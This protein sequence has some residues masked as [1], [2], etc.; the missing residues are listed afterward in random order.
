MLS[1]PGRPVQIVVRLAWTILVLA[2]IAGFLASAW[3]PGDGASGDLPGFRNNGFRIDWVIQDAHQVLQPGDVIREINH[4]SINA[5]ISASPAERM[6]RNG[7]TLTFTVLRNNQ[8]L[9]LPVTLRHLPLGMVI[10]RYWFQLLMAFIQM[11]IGGFMLLKRQDE[12]PARVL[13]LFTLAIFF[14][15]LGDAYNFSPSA[16]YQGWPFWIHF[17]EEQIT[18]LIASATITL[19]CIVF[20]APRNLK[21][22]SLFLINLSL[23]GLPLLVFLLVSFIVTPGSKALYTGNQALISACSVEYLLAIIVLVRKIRTHREQP[24]RSQIQWLVACG[25]FCVLILVPSYF[26][27]LVLGIPPFLTSYT[28]SFSLLIIPLVIAIAI[29]RYRM[30]DIE[31]IL[32]QSLIYSILTA[33]LFGLFVSV[34]ILIQEILFSFLPGGN[35]P[36]SIGIATLITAAVFNPFRN[37]LQNWIDGRFYRERVDMRK[38][39]KDFADNIRFSVDLPEILKALSEFITR[40]LNSA[41]VVIYLAEEGNIFRKAEMRGSVIGFDANISLEPEI[42]SRLAG[43]GY[44]ENKKGTYQLWVPLTVADGKGGL[45]LLGAMVAGPHLMERSFRGDEVQFMRFISDHV[46]VA[47]ANASYIHEQTANV[48]KQIA[49]YHS[50]VLSLSKA[51]DARDSYTYGHSD[52]I[53]LLSQKV[54]D[55]MGISEQGHEVL[56]WAS[57]LHDI[58]KIGVRDSILF[59][60]GKLT[61]E[62]WVEMKKHPDI[63]AD[64]IARLPGLEQVSEIIRC[65][66]ERYDGNGYPR[67]LKGEQIPV[68]ARIISVVDSYFA[69]IDHRVYNIP[70]TP[71]E[72]VEELT[73]CAG[74]QFD[75]GVVA[76]YLTLIQL[77][78]YPNDR[79]SI[80]N[81]L[82]GPPPTEHR[83]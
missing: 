6:L 11:L 35:Y 18:F 77:Q 22:R 62:E 38:V 78:G 65:H 76:I 55:A 4:Q 73:R 61:P 50:V 57:L 28:F 48:R 23:F 39:I 1:S 21:S 41:W 40:K 72:A 54:G 7:A 80:P 20:P 56:H 36:I 37:R 2:A 46:G 25:I 9:E 3:I 15:V 34:I 45:R 47:I 51:I 81:P 33:A 8:V 59:K 5:L 68:E 13:G 26:L 29:F 83:S 42:L 10:R 74:T 31:F 17:G 52:G 43:G 14:Q 30:L 79:F 16:L 69:M 32:Y 82:P 64:I 60:P 75:P 19:F 58:G 53:A 66:H 27:S 67:G 70:K 12:L 63:G 49:L 71:Q 24:A 44:H